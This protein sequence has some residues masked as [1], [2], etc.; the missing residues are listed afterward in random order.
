M[1]SS[2]GAN[3]SRVAGMHAKCLLSDNNVVIG[4]YNH[5][6]ADPRG[7]AQ[8]QR[9]VSIEVQSAELAQALWAA[10]EREEGEAVGLP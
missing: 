8:R 3:V 4:S 9:E 1:L 2:A 5:L 10:F 6:S 7:A